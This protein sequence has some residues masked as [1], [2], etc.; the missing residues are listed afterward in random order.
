M[1]AFHRGLLAV[2][3][4]AAITTALAQEPPPTNL[5]LAEAK[6]FALRNNPRIRSADSNT[7]A[8]ESVVKEVRAARFPTVSAI[9]TGVEAQHSTILAAGTLQTSSLYS[10]LASGISVSQL[11]TD[12]GRTAR[13]TQSADLRRQAQRSQSQTVRE[14]VL[15]QVEQAYFQALSG[16]AAR[17]VAQAAVT[18]RQTTLRQIR[19]LAENAMRSTLDVR[20]AEVALSQAQ[21]DLYQTENLAAEAQANLSAVLGLDHS[22]EF[23]LTD[24]PTPAALEARP[25][26]RIQ[27]ALHKRPEVLA[28]TRI[29]DADRR[30]AEA[31]ARLK[32]PTVSLLGAAGAVPLGDPR[33]PENYSAAGVNITIPVFNGGLFSARRAEAEQRVLAA[34]SDLRALSIQV[35]REVRVAWLEANTAARRLDVTA[36]LVV[37]AREALRLAQT[38]YDAGLGGIVELTQAQ[39]NQT[40]AEI[41]NATARYEYLS[42]RAA[43]DYSSGGLQ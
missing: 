19:S 42:R 32:L 35:S 6:A 38:R 16:N 30:Y 41:Q 17:T 3:G 37:E 18:S 2:I 12:F 43:L 10:R 11:V 9:E 27:D 14:Q 5:T 39:L 28:L 40:S 31:E 20:F 21:L 1:R 26:S 34:D 29:R 23:T 4:G 15:L 24:E 13:L 36:R 7:Q 8:A 33:L 22:M 25:D